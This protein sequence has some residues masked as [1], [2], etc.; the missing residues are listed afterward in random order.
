MALHETGS[1]SGNQNNSVR[2][3]PRAQLEGRVF[4][5]N[6]ERLF[7]APIV[8][9][10]EEGCFVGQLTALT[11]GA[12]VRAVIKSQTLG[13][14]IQIVGTVIRVE[15]GNRTGVA[16]SFEKLAD[17]ARKRIAR[18]VSTSKSQEGLEEVA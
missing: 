1:N 18:L 2:D 11:K 5:H 7:I 14:P 4:I 8:D 17:E 9:I 15:T 3:V 16:I 12:K 6:D 13:Q 10:S